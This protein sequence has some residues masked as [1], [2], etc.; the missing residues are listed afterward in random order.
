[1]AI[2][3]LQAPQKIGWPEHKFQADQYRGMGLQPGMQKDLAPPKPE[4][5]PVP[6]K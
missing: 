3:L 5:S 1:M 6:A 4:K 2:E